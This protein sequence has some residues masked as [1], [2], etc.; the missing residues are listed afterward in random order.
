[1]PCTFFPKAANVFP[2]CC[3]DETSLQDFV[4][5]IPKLQIFTSTSAI[6]ML[7]IANVLRFVAMIKYCLVV[8]YKVSRMLRFFNQNYTNL[9]QNS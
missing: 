3:T 7:N 6:P 2:G 4:S 8:H 5:K 1:M 9:Y